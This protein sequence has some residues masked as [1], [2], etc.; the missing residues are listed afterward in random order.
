MTEEIPI[1]KTR[2]PCLVAGKDQENEK[3]LFPL[4]G[5]RETK[6]HTQL[7]PLQSLVLVK[8]SCSKCDNFLSLFPSFSSNQTGHKH[9]Q[10]QKQ[11]PTTGIAS[12]KLL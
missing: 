5:E 6:V 11:Q 8:Q 12:R 4:F 2:I 7:I 1:K 9:T 3:K 10:Q